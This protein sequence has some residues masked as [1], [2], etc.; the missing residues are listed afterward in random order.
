MNLVVPLRVVSSA[1][2]LGIVILTAG[3]STPAPVLQLADRTAANAGVLATRLQQ[4]AQESDRLYATRVD[5]IG[6]LTG[7]VAAQRSAFDLDVLLTKRA[8]QQAD[9][10]LLDEIRKRRAETDALTAAASGDAA[11]QRRKSLLD[12]QVK[13]D[14]RTAAL[15]AVAEKLATLAQEASAEERARLFARF[16]RAVRDDVQKE[17]ADGSKAS[18]AAQ[19]L[20]DQLK[21]DLKPAAKTK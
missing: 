8:G 4:V 12:A 2:A 15:Q 17:L 6:A 5:N 3:C 7:G 13:I 18:N 21:S 9:L 14:P 16:A 19:A 20:I 11:H 10:E 1:L